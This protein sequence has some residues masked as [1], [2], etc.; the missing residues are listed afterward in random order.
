[1]DDDSPRCGGLET[2]AG[3][4]F[5]VDRREVIPLVFVPGIMGSRL[6]Q[7]STKKIVWDPNR[8][9]AFMWW[10]YSGMP[11][12][13][14]KSWLIGDTFSP[15]FLEPVVDQPWLA[16]PA[17][18][19]TRRRQRNDPFPGRGM[20]GVAW[21]SYGSFIGRL[22]TRERM[23]G[24]PADVAKAFHLPTYCFPFNWTAS[25]RMSG[26]RLAK[27]VEKLI[28]DWVAKGRRCRQVI[29]ITHSM[30]GLVARW[31]MKSGIAGRVLGA[32]HGVQPVDGSAEAYWRMRGGFHPRGIVA[33]VL[34]PNAAAVT[35]L[36]ANMPGGL[37][38]LP[39]KHYRV[40]G[41]A[42][43]LKLLDPRGRLLE[44]YPR[45]NPYSEIYR[46][47]T[48]FW[49]LIDT[50][51]VNPQVRPRRS[52]RS[53]YQPPPSSS[54]PWPTLDKLLTEAESFH[55]ELGRYRHPRTRTFHG[56]GTQHYTTAQV[57][58]RMKPY[59]TDFQLPD[60]LHDYRAY[61]AYRRWHP[62]RDVPLD[63]PPDLQAL[64]RQQIRFEYQS[65]GLDVH[66]G[67]NRYPLTMELQRPTGGGDGTVPEGSGSAL[68][69]PEIA[70]ELP[71][72]PTP[73]AFQ[74]GATGFAGIEHE[75]AYKE[76]KVQ[77]FAL[78]SIADLCRHVLQ[79]GGGSTKTGA[80]SGKARP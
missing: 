60:R 4:T 1:M 38:L 30:G 36:L 14:R 68:D 59:Y 66:L 3:H 58:Y 63:P 46:Q 49:R 52:R 29:L 73:R 24:W 6:R 19:V 79:D 64:A 11:P 10:H 43:W 22:I 76:K 48:V 34:G 41:S 75:G 53:P 42:P 5:V 27:D 47:K 25:C 71:D 39:N 44:H 57:R 35:P 23:G 62:P 50:S 20:E 21:S 16:G 31:A 37:Q 28:A 33:R 55:D 80:T 12:S 65:P 15:T 61:F 51:L 17:P 40:D 26:E 67:M 56:T 8:L 72:D 74:P 9:F 54:N 13:T 7:T 45:A 32:I 78:T 69:L 77:E 70:G 2:S 18:S